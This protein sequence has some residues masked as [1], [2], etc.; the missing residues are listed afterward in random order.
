MSDITY[1]RTGQGWLYLTTV[2]DLYDR[3][4]IGWSLS[5]TMKAQDTSI[6]ALKMARLYRPLQDHDNLIFHS[7]RGIQYACTEFISI[8]GKNITRSMSG[9]A[10]HITNT[11]N[12]IKI[13][14]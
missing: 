9:I 2:I 11:L 7:D 14:E 6:A 8:V 13:D 4:V 12:E 10:K 5:E 3:K 1:I